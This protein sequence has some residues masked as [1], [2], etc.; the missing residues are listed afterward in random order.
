MGLSILID[1]GQV[2]LDS[3]LVDLLPEDCPPRPSAR[4]K[5]I[6]LRHLL[7][8]TAGVTDVGE[9]AAVTVE[10][11]KKT[12]LSSS[13]ATQPG[14]RFFYNSMNTYM[15]SAVIERVS[16]MTLEDFLRENLLHPMGIRT[17]FCEK[18][19]EGI[20]KGGW[21]MF[22]APPDMAKLGQ[23]LLQGGQWE[24]RQLLPRDFLVEATKSQ[25][26][27]GEGGSPWWSGLVRAGVSLVGWAVKE[28]KRRS[29]LLTL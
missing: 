10:D 17:F 25:V 16:G 4:M 22:L 1:R 15:L 29:T 28:G 12:F 2:S 7:T 6:T 27:T 24:G 8:M 23:L 14:K 3:R 5:T 9:G 20:G 26:V 11:W 13:V 21:G 18:S 19:P